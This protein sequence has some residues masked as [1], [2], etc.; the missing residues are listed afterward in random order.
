MPSNPAELIISDRFEKVLQELA[1]RYDIVLMDAPPVLGAAE[2]V[3]L[4][5]LSAINLLVVRSEQQTPREIELTLNKLRQ[6]GA[7][8]KGFVLNDL[9]VRARHAY[10]GYHYYSY[11]K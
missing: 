7:H 3:T 1:T 9:Q 11:N 2:S 8:P 5:R 4:A 6:A 10:G